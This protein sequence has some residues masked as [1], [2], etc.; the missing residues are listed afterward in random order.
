MTKLLVTN[1][2]TENVA[3][4][5]EMHDEGQLD[6]L[7]ERARRAQR[8]WARVPVSERVGC[9]ERFCE[10]LLDRKESIALEISQQMGKP[11]AQAEGEVMRCT[12]RASYVASIALDALRDRVVKLDDGIFRK[13]ALEP[14]GVLLD[15]AAWNYP[16]L[17]AINMLAPAVLAGNA[18]LIKHSS[19][20]PLCA[21]HL[22]RAFV[23]AGV[24]EGIVTALMLD[25][26]AAE[27]LLTDPR[28]RGI[29][30]TGSVPAGHHVYKTA[31]A[32]LIDVGLELGGKDPAYV[33]GDVD[34]DTVVPIVADGAFYNCGQSCCAVERIYVARALYGE[35]V[36]RFVETVASY[37]LGDPLERETY[38]GPLAQR[39]AIRTLEEQTRDAVAKGGR[40][41]LG[42]EATTHQGLGSY[43]QPTVLVDVDHEMAV[44]R[45]ESF[46]PIIG[47]M[48][49]DDDS[50][51]L[52][53]MNDS[54]FGLTASIWTRDYETAM[55]LAPEVEAGTV[56]LNRCDY[57]DPAL[58]WTGVKESGKGAALSELGFLE[59]VQ[60][61]SYHFVPARS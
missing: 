4:E 20:T 19:L 29:F 9:V 40:L 46:G 16:L 37:T 35:F 47:I 8:E 25:R 22:E 2:A 5:I 55:G 24:P 60:P 51:A 11:V 38:L 53:L 30:F 7:I 21:T 28:I 6:R 50:E 59:M 23:E 10:R 31:S 52:R 14:K 49:V 3:F 32:N 17:I 58:V 1:P 57:V 13:L 26:K 48:P 41:L 43:F 34:L 61:K 15:I 33:R 27:G 42:G 54:E 36:E 45:D 44:M 12:E 56:F 39:S 18:A